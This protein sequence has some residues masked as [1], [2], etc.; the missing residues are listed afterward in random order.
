M[1]H[2][3][4]NAEESSLHGQE[5]QWDMRYRV[6]RISACTNLVYLAMTVV[7]GRRKHVPKVGRLQTT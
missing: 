7:R 4:R 3:S 5:M 2:D 6:L 1:L